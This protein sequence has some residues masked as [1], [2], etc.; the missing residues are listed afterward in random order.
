MPVPIVSPTTLRA[1][2]RRA[3]PPLAE[4]RA[5]RVVVERRRQPEP[6]L[7]P[8]AQREILPAEV[9]RDE[10]DALLA[11]QRTRRAHADA[12]EVAPRAPVCSHGVE[13]HSFH[14]RRPCAPATPS[15]PTYDVG[16]DAAHRVNV[17]MPSA[18][19]A[20]ATMF[21]PPRST[22][23]MYCSRCAVLMPARRGEEERERSFGDERR[24]RGRACSDSGRGDSAAVRA[25][26]MAGR[27]R[28]LARPPMHAAPADRSRTSAPSG[29][30]SP[31]SA[32]PWPTQ[33][34]TAPSRSSPR[35]P[36]RPISSADASSDNSPSHRSPWAP[37]ATMRRRA[38]RRPRPPITTTR[39]CGARRCASSGIVWPPLGSPHAARRERHEPLIARHAV[40]RQ[41]RVHG[42][43]FGVARRERRT[44]LL[45][46]PARA[47]SA[48]RASAGAPRD[49]GRRDRAR[50]WCTAAARPSV[51]ADSRRD[52][53][54][55]ARA[56][57]S[58][59][60]PVRAAP[61]RSRV[62]AVGASAK[63][64][65]QAA[66]AP[67]LS[68]AITVAHRGVIRQQ[69]RRC[70][71]HD[72]VH[73]PAMRQLRE[74][75][76]REHVSPRNDV[77]MTSVED[78]RSLHASIHLEDGEKRF[79]RNLHRSHLLHALLSFLLLLEEL[80]LAA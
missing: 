20:P 3:L 70:R 66:S 31:P 37:A 55:A 72:D 35:P 50:A 27:Q 59:T 17:A 52:A 68:Y 67:R 73:R 71:R 11:I 74:Q 47:R 40:P 45:G 15:S 9:R 5:V 19:M 69:C 58:A 12:D 43:T 23:T 38:P 75:R 7:D 34:A 57:R 44:E 13:D 36:H 22:P 28:I 1:A 42:R 8:I 25:G 32:F 78:T 56:P 30:R 21:V 51:E 39:A 10:H 54:R 46:A 61:G 80:A 49:A 64:A 41:Q 77:W 24:A 60:S 2:A 65:A 76:R 48:A 53:R 14:E 4:R 62:R 33:D 29:R 63:Q 18:V 16:R 79:L 26:R 6:V